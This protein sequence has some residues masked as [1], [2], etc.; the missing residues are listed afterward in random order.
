MWYVGHKL[1]ASEIGNVV[2]G[3]CFDVESELSFASCS[4]KRPIAESFPLGNLELSL[5][6]LLFEKHLVLKWDGMRV[7]MI[8]VST[9]FVRVETMLSF[10]SGYFE[11]WHEC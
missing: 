11:G 4:T 7:L 3:Y 9:Q 5:V 1:E 8:L 10:E 2:E 6:P